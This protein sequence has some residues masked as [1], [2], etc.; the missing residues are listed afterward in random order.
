MTTPTP[1]RL[2][3]AELAS[4]P[5]R[6]LGTSEWLLVAQ[7]RVDGFAEVTDDHQWIHVDP[8]RAHSG[9]FG[10]TIAHGYLT[11]SLLPRLLGTLLEV[12]DEV[13]GT[14][15]GLDKIRFTRPVPVGSSIRLAAQII[16][17]QVRDD[18]GVKFAVSVQIQIQ[19]QDRPAMVGQSIYLAYDK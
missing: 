12:T 4:S 2:T 17:A 10:G 19:G 1:L 3:V 15:Y 9:P 18:Q 16:D 8:E 5:Q 11:L 7:D 13:R 14:N 6:D